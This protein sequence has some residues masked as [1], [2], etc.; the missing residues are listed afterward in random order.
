MDVI[1]TQVSALTA[2]SP[3]P[4][5]DALHST[6]FCHIGT[7]HRV[8]VSEDLDLAGRRCAQR[9]RRLLDVLA[10]LLGARTVDHQLEDLPLLFRAI[11]A[12]QRREESAP[13]L[14]LA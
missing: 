10:R 7:L 3:A 9:Q 14:A 4:Y 2:V 12:S 11:Q 1:A 13:L 8:A 5:G 6:I